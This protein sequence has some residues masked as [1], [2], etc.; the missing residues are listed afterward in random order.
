[1]TLSAQSSIAGDIRRRI[2][3]PLVLVGMMG[4]GKTR[5]G[6]CL[7]R[8]LDLPF[9]DSDREIE[10]AAGM[11][12]PEIFKTL[13]EPEFRAGEKRVIARLL[14]RGPSVLATGGG[15]VMDPDTQAAIAGKAVSLWIRADMDLLLSRTARR[16][17][18]PLLE[19]GDP[20]EILEA[21]AAKR[22]PVYE[23]A[24]MVIDS[25]DGPVDITVDKALE[26]LDGFL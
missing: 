3:R 8:V 23:R 4:A 26:K 17:G 5:V 24:D 6:Q 22:Y 20:R 10:K 2:D 14:E 21:L 18:R 13:G 25:H 7:A 1:M 16:G 12:V 11:T 9:A 19:N 15:A